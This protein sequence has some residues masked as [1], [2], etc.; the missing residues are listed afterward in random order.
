MAELLSREAV[1]L[2]LQDSYGSLKKKLMKSHPLSFLSFVYKG[3]L[4]KSILL[5]MRGR[6]T[7]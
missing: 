4:Y 3:T 5:I 2:S 7:N 6:K 1:P